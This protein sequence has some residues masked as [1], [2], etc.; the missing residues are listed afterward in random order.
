MSEKFDRVIAGSWQSLNEGEMLEFK[1]YC[2]RL[3][4]PLDKWIDIAV[5]TCFYRLS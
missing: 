3:G 2:S 1:V 4:L 5:P